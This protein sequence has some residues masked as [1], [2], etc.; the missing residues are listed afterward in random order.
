M[1]IKPHPEAAAAPVEPG[2]NQTV[3][4][5]PLAYDLLVRMCC[6]LA[7]VR[8]ITITYSSVCSHKIKYVVFAVLICELERL[9]KYTLELKHRQRYRDIREELRFSGNGDSCLSKTERSLLED[10]ADLS[11]SA[12][13]QE[14]NYSH[15]SIYHVRVQCSAR[16]R[17]VKLVW[18]MDFPVDVTWNRAVY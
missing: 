10:T 18:K 7:S 3:W 17:S 4:L 16:E 2:N 15:Y 6:I 5:L 9:G 12:S 11:I 8:N 13:L 14:I 1:H